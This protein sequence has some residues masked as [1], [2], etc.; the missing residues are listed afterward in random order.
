MDTRYF[1]ASLTR[2]TTL[3]DTA[4]TVETLSK[5]SVPRLRAILKETLKF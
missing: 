1:F 2:I 5:E 4:W 3:A